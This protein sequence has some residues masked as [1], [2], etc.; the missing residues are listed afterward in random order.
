M[1]DHKYL[2]TH[3]WEGWGKCFASCGK[4]KSW[5]VARAVGGGRQANNYGNCSAYATEREA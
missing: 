5:K 1:K 2:H 4:W 3:N